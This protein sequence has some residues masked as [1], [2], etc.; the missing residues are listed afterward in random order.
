MAHYDRQAE[1]VRSVETVLKVLENLFFSL[2]ISEEITQKYNYLKENKYRHAGLFFSPVTKAQYPSIGTKSDACDSEQLQ[3]LE[4]TFT[5]ILKSQIELYDSILNSI[6]EHGELLLESIKGSVRLSSSFN[7]QSAY[8]GV[9]K[10]KVMEALREYDQKKISMQSNTRLR[11]TITLGY[12]PLSEMISQMLYKS[13]LDK[14]KVLGTMKALRNELEM[15]SESYR[16]KEG[17]LVAEMEILHNQISKLDDGIAAEVMK[18]RNDYDNL[19]AKLKEQHEQ[20]LLNLHHT[21]D[22]LRNQC[23]VITEEKS[24]QTGEQHKA[25]IEDYMEKLEHVVIAMRERLKAYYEI[26]RP[27]QTSWKEE[28]ADTEIEEI[29]YTE[30]VLYCAN[31]YE[32]DGKWLNEQMEIL[33]KENKQLKEIAVA[34]PQTLQK[35]RFL[36]ITSCGVRCGIR[37]RL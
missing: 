18:V 23:S 4:N 29:L 21:I 17:K 2:P 9:A 1:S 16:I 28:D 30:F 22:D 19:L 14:N 37:S 34:S 24:F 15:Q 33:E 10:D 31:K 7:N 25:D 35:V 27:L 26:Q 13:E 8:K 32:A 12:N 11:A 20:E 36:V 5:N 3:T 6:V